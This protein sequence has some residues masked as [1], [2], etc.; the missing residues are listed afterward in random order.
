MT[1]TEG[2]ARRV[3][4]KDKE[5]VHCGEEWHNEKQTSKQAPRMRR[6]GR[7]HGRNFKQLQTQR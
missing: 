3:V 2:R 5:G 4:G 1:G 6:N 7:W